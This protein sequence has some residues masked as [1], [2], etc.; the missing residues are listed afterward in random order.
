MSEQK[1]NFISVDDLK[2]LVHKE[3][4]YKIQISDND[5][6]LTTIYVNK[7]V[8][9]AALG[10]AG[11]L[12][13]KAIA[14]IERLPGAADKEL[15]RAGD[16]A[17]SSLS[18]EVGKIAQRIAGDAAAATAAKAK[19]EAARWQAGALLAGLAVGT[20]ATYLGVSGANAIN[21]STAREKVAA[22]ELRAE[23]A[24]ADAKKRADE[25]ISEITEK[26]GAAVAAVAARNAWAS[27]A[28]G[29][30]AHKLA[31]AGDLAK[32]AGCTG[33]G[34]EKR[35]DAKSGATWC[36]IPQKDGIFSGTTSVPQ[37]RVPD[38][39]N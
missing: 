24:E 11:E 21:M 14:V 38:Y 29:Q 9:G 31:A 16:A 37:F 20:I 8:L 10:E 18:T 28:A 17:I 27:S 2:S 34:W 35:K 13:K 4:G 25:A 19:T 6:L 5:P 30:V 15:K 3:S 36:Y 1:K 26:S 12:Q 39:R 33:D 22:A 32:I 7:A 23:T